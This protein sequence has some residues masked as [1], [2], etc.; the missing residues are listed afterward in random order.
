[1]PNGLTT[2]SEPSVADAGG[3]D[4]KEVHRVWD[5]SQRGIKA[6]GSAEAGPKVPGFI[7][8]I[9]VANSDAGA[10]RCLRSAEIREEA[11][12]GLKGHNCQGLVC[13]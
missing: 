5:V 1:M 10:G 7:A 4:L 3:E 2:G 9:T 12:A 8:P 11:I 13:R 6:E